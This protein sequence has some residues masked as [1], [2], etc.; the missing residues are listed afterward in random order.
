M[1]SGLGSVGKFVQ[2][3]TTVKNSLTAV[4]LVAAV[5]FGLLSFHLTKGNS[6]SVGGVMAGVAA[7]ISSGVAFGAGLHSAFKERKK[8]DPA[9]RPVTMEI[10]GSDG[11]IVYSETI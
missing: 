7:L 1:I 8:E 2:E 4:A 3:N 10:Y 6:Q 9:E 5:G 11:K